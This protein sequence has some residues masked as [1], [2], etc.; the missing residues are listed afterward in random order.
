MW[1]SLRMEIPKKGCTSLPRIEP[2]EILFTDPM[3]SHGVHREMEV[4]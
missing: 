4:S 1:E 2:G 3:L